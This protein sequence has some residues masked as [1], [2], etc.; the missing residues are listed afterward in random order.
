T[1]AAPRPAPPPSCFRL[2]RTRPAH[3]LQRDRSAHRLDGPQRRFTMTMSETTTRETM[4][5]AAGPHERA[6]QSATDVGQA[7]RWDSLAAGALRAGLR[8][9]RQSLPGALIAAGGGAMIYRGATGRCP[10]YSALGMDTSDNAVAR[11][12]DYIGH[13]IH[14]AESYL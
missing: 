2:S 7:E 14:V 5:V 13:G 6:E 8:I 1:C 11:P 12:E 9:Q 4:G 10:R 3:A